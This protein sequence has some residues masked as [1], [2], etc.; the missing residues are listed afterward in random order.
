MQN[1]KDSEKITVEEIIGTDRVTIFVGSDIQTLEDIIFKGR[2]TIRVKYSCSHME[3]KGK[4]LQKVLM[5]LHLKSKPQLKLL[6][7]PTMAKY[8]SSVLWSLYN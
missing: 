8:S 4:E 7:A 1:D 5:T 6:L 3:R 2:K